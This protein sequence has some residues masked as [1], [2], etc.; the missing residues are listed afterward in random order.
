[1]G[2]GDTL[3]L[4]LFEDLGCR[5]LTKDS[6]VDSRLTRRR[7]GSSREDLTTLMIKS[8][9]NTGAYANQLIEN[10]N[11]RLNCDEECRI[12]EAAWTNDV[13]CLVVHELHSSDRSLE[14]SPRSGNSKSL[15]GRNGNGVGLSE[16]EIPGVE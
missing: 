11:S 6:S 3:G 14:A 9:Y 4:A 1:M 10:P 12:Q 5:F 16:R 13:L 8:K 15:L 2:N 7:S